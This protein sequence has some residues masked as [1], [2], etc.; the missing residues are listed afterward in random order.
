MEVP[1]DWP[2]ADE[3]TV[4]AACGSDDDRYVTVE[5]LGLVWG[6]A[7]D[8]GLAPTAVGDYSGTLRLRCCHDC[9]TEAGIDALDEVRTLVDPDA[10]ATGGHSFALDDERVAAAARLDAERVAVGDLRSLDYRS[11]PEREHVRSQDE[12]VEAVLDAWFDRG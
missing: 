6:A 7:M 12:A 8:G 1:D 4:C 5:S 10:R 9:W 3:P 11:D 2:Y